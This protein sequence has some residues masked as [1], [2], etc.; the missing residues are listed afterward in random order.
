MGVVFT[1]SPFY[2]QN[3]TIERVWVEV[4]TRVNYPIKSALIGMCDD[5]LDDDVCKAC[6]SWFSIKVAT[7]GTAVFVDAWNSNTIPG[8]SFS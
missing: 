6:V 2:V 3:H 5:N 8:N 1:V 4:N 7:I